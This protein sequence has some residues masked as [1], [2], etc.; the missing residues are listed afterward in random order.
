MT[1]THLLRPDPIVTTAQSVAPGALSQNAT[2]RRARSAPMWPP[3][4]PVA[5]SRGDPS[6]LGGAR[7]PRRRAPHRRV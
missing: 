6:R 2:S 1:H 7:C 4:L 5:L 3:I